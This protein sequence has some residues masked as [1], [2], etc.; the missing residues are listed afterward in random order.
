MQW[1]PAGLQENGLL[2][3]LQT[4]FEHAGLWSLAV[5]LQLLHC[6]VQLPQGAG[7]PDC[8]AHTQVATHTQS[9][10]VT[11]AG[12]CASCWQHPNIF[13]QSR[14]QSGCH[15]GHMDDSLAAVLCFCRHSLLVFRQ[16]TVPMHLADHT[17][18]RA[19]CAMHLVRNV[20][21]NIP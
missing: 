1:A 20:Q 18:L 17:T 9:Q 15:G 3:W 10:L 12:P 14:C 2:I 19:A 8:P 7:V 4:Q 5:H 13:W 21:F 6:I 16:S 11:P